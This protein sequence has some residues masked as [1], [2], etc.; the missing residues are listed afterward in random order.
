[1]SIFTILIIVCKYCN[2]RY[3]L[4]TKYTFK[5]TCYYL[6]FASALALGREAGG[7]VMVR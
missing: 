1:M 2:Y 4:G 5:N 7:D 6:P 3:I